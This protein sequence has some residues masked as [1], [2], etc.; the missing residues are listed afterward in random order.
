MGKRYHSALHILASTTTCRTTTVRHF[1]VQFDGIEYLRKGGVLSGFVYRHVVRIPPLKGMLLEYDVA[2]E[3]LGEG[4]MGRVVRVMHRR[5]AQWRAAKRIKPGQLRPRKGLSGLDIAKREI[6]VMKGLKHPNICKI[7]D[8]YIYEEDNT[9]GQRSLT[10]DGIFF[11]HYVVI[12]IVMELVDGPNL[13]DY[14]LDTDNGLGE[15]HKLYHIHLL[16]TTYS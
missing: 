10:H 13:R 12:D 15:S 7:Y 3:Q 2:S 16:T 14:A 5:S 6:T 4:A 1:T 8:Y 11:A 9:L